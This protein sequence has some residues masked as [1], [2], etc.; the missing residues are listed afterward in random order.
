MKSVGVFAGIFLLA[1]GCQTPSGAI[2]GGGGYTKKE[3]Q[4]V[5]RSNL[6]GI[7]KCYK[8][9]LSSN[10]KLKGEVRVKF[11]IMPDGSV[12]KN[13][14]IVNDTVGDP[15]LAKCVIDTSLSWKFPVSRV[16][17]ATV[18]TYPFNFNP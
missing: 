13:V 14:S 16:D 17:K 1:S 7:E 2:I 4:T 10:P 8:V 15:G 18:V 9:E 6:D 5:I 12:N 3:V 11:D